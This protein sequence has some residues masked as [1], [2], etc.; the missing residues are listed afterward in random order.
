MNLS[1]S[2]PTTTVV[3]TAVDVELFTKRARSAAP[4]AEKCHD[5]NAE[6]FNMLPFR[7]STCFRFKPFMTYLAQLHDDRHYGT[8]SL[9]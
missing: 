2:R 7:C 5:V 6:G 3:Y 8:L 4:V 9:D 1:S